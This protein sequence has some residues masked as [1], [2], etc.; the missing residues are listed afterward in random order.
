MRDNRLKMT[1][2]VTGVCF[3]HSDDFTMSL[4][5]TNTSSTPIHYDANQTNF[6]T[7]RAPA[8]EQKRR[9]EDD[10]CVP[11]TGNGQKTAL[12]LA[13]GASATFTAV[14]PADKS[15]GKRESCRRLETGGY[16]VHAT[17]LV[18]DESYEDGYCDIAKDTQYKADPV[19]ITLTS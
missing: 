10:D 2:S 8:G 12:T 18:C 3:K 15:V 9:W 5:V 6:F 1:L 4:V 16:D 7:V 13:P 19:N 14:Y 11:S 17:F